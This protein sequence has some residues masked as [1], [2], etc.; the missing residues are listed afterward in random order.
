MDLNGES[1]SLTAT[2]TATV[3][4]TTTSSSITTNQQN[5]SSNGLLNDSILANG[6]ATAAHEAA[7]A[8][9]ATNGVNS[10]FMSNQTPSSSIED[11]TLRECEAYVNKHS[12][13][14]LLKDCIVQ[15]CLK[16]PENPIG[17]LRQ[18]F[19]RLEKVCKIK[20]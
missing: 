6:T 16:K 20:F 1:A 10:T 3:T 15:L 18:H 4:S 13:K 12:I 19:E 17:F 2:F 14:D 7:V 11:Q 5:S 8:A 9:T